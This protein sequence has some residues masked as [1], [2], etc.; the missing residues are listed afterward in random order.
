MAGGGQPAGR[1][2]LHVRP[3]KIIKMFENVLETKHFSEFGAQK[4]LEERLPR[5]RFSSSQPVG[6]AMTRLVFSHRWKKNRVD[7]FSP[8][9]VLSPVKQTKLVY[10]FMIVKSSLRAMIK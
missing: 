10:C 4:A 1:A 8:V 3:R 7:L 6:A 5:R 2:G 9:L